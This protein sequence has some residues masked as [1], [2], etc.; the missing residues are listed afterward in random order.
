ML[1]DMAVTVHEYPV[2]LTEL[3]RWHTVELL[4][5][6]LAT[7]AC[8]PAQHRLIA[9]LLAQFTSPARSFAFTQAAV[10]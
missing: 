8:T 1:T 9:D 5:S 3:E 4:E 10:S 6:V 7:H 2:A